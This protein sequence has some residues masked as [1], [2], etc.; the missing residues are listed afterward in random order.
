MTRLLTALAAV[1]ALCAVAHASPQDK[2]PDRP[3]EKVDRERLRKAAQL[4]SVGPRGWYYGMTCDGRLFQGGED[5]V[6][7]DAAELRSRL[8]DDE[9]D[10][11][12][13][14]HL[15]AAYQR[16][17]DA[18]REKEALGQAKT[19]AARASEERPGDGQAIAEAAFCLAAM[20]DDGRAD[21]LAA[22]AASKDAG[23]WAAAAVRG[24]LF[25]LR[26]VAKAAGR[27]FA[28]LDSAYAWIGNDDARTDAMDAKALAAASASY[29]EAAS[30]AERAKLTGR[31]ASSVFVRR[32][33]LLG[34]L[35]A[36]APDSE[37]D[38]DAARRDA[39]AASDWRRA[40]ERQADE[41]DAVTMLALDDAMGARDEETGVRSVQ[42][43]EQLPDAAREKIRAHVTK[44]AVIAA[45]TDA[46]RAARALQGGAALHWFVRR[47]AAATES[48]LKRSLVLDG[49]LRQSWNAYVLILVAASRFSDLAN[50]C[51]AWVETEDGARQRMMLAKA[52]WA[53]G[54]AVRAEEHWRAAL[55]LEPKSP[56]ANLGVA[57]LVLRRAKE[58]AEIEEA[59][60]L[61][62]AA[63]S[64]ITAQGGAPDTQRA[65]GCD[66]ADAVALGLAGDL[67]ACEKAARGLLDRYGEFPQ[68]REI[69]AAIGR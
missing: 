8:A 26:A 64:A 56:D 13:W 1:A 16:E 27:R 14:L 6:A 60:R 45:G 4:P 34:L 22:A 49:G 69:L 32:S 30:L 7:A 35:S 41:P 62:R 61:V 9:T 38:E 42:S 44:L 29:D 51:A 33:R 67:D 66:L 19:L 37:P 47:D 40:L 43:F 20:G 36:A 28:T 54:D 15:A 39:R 23:A 59:Q 52:L 25:V 63:R 18:P 58:A 46:A 65:A 10:P 53:S 17:N 68:A 57:V 12:A 50:L 24:D 31:A 48:A 3:Q 5:P 2:G 11:R 55:A 21:E